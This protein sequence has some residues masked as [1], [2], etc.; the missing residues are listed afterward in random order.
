MKLDGKT[1]L[2]R[3]DPAKKY[4]EVWLGGQRLYHALLVGMCVD[5]CADHAK[6]FGNNIERYEI[7]IRHG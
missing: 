6:E 2:V 5:F 1:Q 3:P 7:T 4:Y